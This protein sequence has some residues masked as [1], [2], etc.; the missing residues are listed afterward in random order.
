[1]LRIYA[2]DCVSYDTHTN[3]T[4]LAS[5][6]KHSVVVIRHQRGIDPNTL[7]AFAAIWDK[8]VQDTHSGDASALKSE[9]TVLSQNKAE[10]IPRANQVTITGEVRFDGYEGL[11]SVDLHHIVSVVLEGI[12]VV[13]VNLM[14]TKTFRT[15]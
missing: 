7:P 8:T 6:L 14:L 12:A 15:I 5:C 11:P 4:L 10:R 1:M 3:S 9:N 13:L 2:V